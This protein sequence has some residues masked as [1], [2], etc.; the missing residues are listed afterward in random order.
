MQ[1]LAEVDEK[2][3]DASRIADRSLNAVWNFC[4]DYFDAVV[5]GFED[6]G[7]FEPEHSP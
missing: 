2:L 5:H 6:C 7:G 1:R 4:D 3:Y